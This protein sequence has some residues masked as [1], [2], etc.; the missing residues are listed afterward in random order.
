MTNSDDMKNIYFLVICLLFF[1]SCGEKPIEYDILIKNA[2]IYNGSGEKP[3]VGLVAIN[4]DK[5]ADL[6]N[7]ENVKGKQEIDAKG[8]AVSPGF[9]NMLSW[10]TESLIEDGRGMSD[11][12]QG[13]TLE[14]MGEGWSMGPL[15]DKMKEDH[16]KSQGDIKYDIE[17]TTLGE[18]LE[19]LEKK[20]VA[21]NV[22]SFMGATTAR[23]HEMG[24]ENRLPSEQELKRMQ[25]LVRQAM[26]E[27]AMGVGSSL[28]YAPAFYADTEELIAL[29]QVA[30]EYNG[31]YITHMR[32]EA[33][34]LI[35]AV[36]EVLQIATEAN[37]SA[38]I[39]H[40]KA[41]GKNNWP[42][43]DQVI[44]KI[45]TAQANGIDITTNMY[46]YIAGATGLDASMPPWVQEGGYDEWVARLKD[47]STRAQV[48]A[49]MKTDATDWENLYFSAGSADKLL[50]VGFKSDSLKK[51]TGKTL[52]EVS[53]LRG[54]DPE[55][56]AMDLVIQDGSR[57]G[58]VYFLMS[59]ANVKKQLQ[60]PYMS[61]GSDAGAP[62]AEGVFLKSSN[63]PRA[64]GNFARLLGKY[65]REEQIIPL[66]E[67]IRKLTLLPAAHLRIRNR[68]MLKVGY[69]ADVVIFDPATIQDKA[70]F[71]NP[72]QY[73][74]GVEH[75]IVNG[76]QVLEDGEPT[77]KFGGRVVRGPGWT[78][79][80]S[81][82]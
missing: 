80:K 62:A 9:I 79:W 44:E 42:K 36:D 55:D 31:R 16:L 14:V 18:Y 2:T 5:I 25:D 26:E 17:W 6:G 30:G 28:I 29:C 64:Y 4:G 73:A 45:E 46:N 7:L 70:T 24:Y 74:V 20:G 82:K 37:I 39:Y 43:M 68:G 34:K 76:V 3:I 58:T 33:N 66:E 27:G 49:E 19:F 60:L 67:A 32:S 50:L 54:T 72:H 65:V 21:P 81:I 12:K 35:E 40:L 71:E 8:M 13:I 51:Y 61:F 38:E 52:L 69:Y 77:G 56:T 63:H 53:Q 78:G 15:N 1:A 75:V 11:I 10:A 57:V 41:G 59:E 22:A 23:I 47:P 48:K